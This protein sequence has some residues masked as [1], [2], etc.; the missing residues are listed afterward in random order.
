MSQQ[1]QQQQQHN[2]FSQKTP[3][4]PTKLL[5]PL[6]STAEA[7]LPTPVN[8]TI[9]ARVDD[10]LL[11]DQHGFSLDTLME[12]AGLSVA[13]AIVDA[14]CLDTSLTVV[15]MC[16]PGNNGGDGLVCARHL[17][18]FG[19]K[20]IHVVFSS[21]ASSARTDDG[22]FDHLWRQLNALG[23]V[24]Y[25]ADVDDCKEGKEERGRGKRRKS[26][27]GKLSNL[28]VD[29]VD[30]WVDCIFGF[31]FNP[32]KGPIRTPYDD[33]IRRMNN[34]VS[35]TAKAKTGIVVAVDVPSGWH[36]DLGLDY[37]KAKVDNDDDDMPR[38]VMPDVLVSLTVPKQ[39]VNCSAVTERRRVNEQWIHYVGGRFIPP[40]VASSLKLDLPQYNG[41]GQ[42]VRV[43]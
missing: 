12:L 20:R 32:E 39:F 35:V 19:Y 3:C 17:W 1:Q 6:T 40:A 22:K 36:V 43:E 8:S 11:S 23:I 9:A 14:T 42:I 33:M 18:H 2:T 24:T 41:V 38:L 13:E 26:S 10:Q 5:S 21:R 4:P 16:G 25:D 29:D 7:R 30:V 31:S 28:N 27:G 15:I 34:S 37:H